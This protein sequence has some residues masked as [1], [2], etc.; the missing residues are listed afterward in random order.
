[1]LGLLFYILF[2][3]VDPQYGMFT[4]P[5]APVLAQFI[6]H[7]RDQVK[8]KQVIEVIHYFYF[9]FWAYKKSIIIIIIAKLTC[10]PSLSLNVQAYFYKT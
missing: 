7:S 3:I 8:Q 1:M 6:W 9:S 10:G 4:W 2:K 5:S